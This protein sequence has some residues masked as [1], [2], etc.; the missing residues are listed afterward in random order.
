MRQT[1]RVTPRALLFDLDN[2]LLFE[3]EVTLRSIRRA[4]ERA[5]GR[6]N[7]D[8]LSA[9][10]ARIAEERWRAAPTFA[11]ADAMGM[12]W[13]EGLWGE[14]RGGEGDGLRAV[15]EFAP[16]FRREVWRDSLAACGVTDDTLAAELIDSYRRA[17]RAGELLDP[18]ANA[19]LDDLSRDHRLALVTN[20]APDVQGEKI[21]RAD[22]GRY[23]AA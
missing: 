14:F 17:R 22:L 18:E 23:F 11:Y 16:Q 15:G 20:G 1:P 8:E 3:D 10:V 12:W 5:R 6:A 21:A 4:C 13:G 2:T 19:V 9:A 7:T